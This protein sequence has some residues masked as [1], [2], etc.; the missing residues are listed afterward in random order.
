[1]TRAHLGS[2]DGIDEDDHFKS[3]YGEKH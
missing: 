3:G 1:V 2:G